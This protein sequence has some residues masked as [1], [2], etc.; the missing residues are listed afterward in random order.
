MLLFVFSGAVLKK[1]KKEA[2]L[3]NPLLPKQVQRVNDAYELLKSELEDTFEVCR[4]VKDTVDPTCR[5][6][7]LSSSLGCVLAL[8]MCTSPNAKW[9]SE[10]EDTKIYQV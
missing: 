2:T 7:A 3:N 10:M 4:K 6:T 5:A 9:K 8:G 1:L